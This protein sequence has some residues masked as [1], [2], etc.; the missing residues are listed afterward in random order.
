[1]KIKKGVQDWQR[2]S[3]SSDAQ[4]KPLL[5]PYRFNGATLNRGAYRWG[6]G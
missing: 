1:V 4:P 6:E 2:K 3:K 5:M